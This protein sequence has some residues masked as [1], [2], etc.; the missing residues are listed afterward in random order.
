MWGMSLGL[1]TLSHGV[2]G[3][4][5]ARVHVC[6][7]ACSCVCTGVF[8]CVHMCSRVYVHGTWCGIY[9]REL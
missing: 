5:C 7:Q 8:M 9:L 2:C 3:S 4:M 1:G 6:A